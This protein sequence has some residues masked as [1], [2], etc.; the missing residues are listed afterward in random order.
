M[1]I[2]I[3]LFFIFKETIPSIISRHAMVSRFHFKNKWFT[4]FIFMENANGKHTVQLQSAL[5]VTSDIFIYIV[6][7]SFKSC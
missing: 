1:L 2:L 7:L 5:S 4:Y 3:D 6:T